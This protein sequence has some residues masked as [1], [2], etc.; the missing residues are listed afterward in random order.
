M[1]EVRRRFPLMALPAYRLPVRVIVRV[2]VAVIYQGDDMVDFDRRTP[3]AYLTER[4]S[5]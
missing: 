4:I 3:A 5:G 2:V 1:P